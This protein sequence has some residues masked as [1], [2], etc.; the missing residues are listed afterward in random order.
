MESGIQEKHFDDADSLWRHLS[1]P[2]RDSDSDGEVIYRGHADADWE[3]VPTVLRPQ[4]IELLQDLIGRPMN[5]E[6][7]AWTELYMLQQFIRGCDEAGVAVPNDSVRF[8][9]INLTDRNFRKYYE[10]PNTWPS[11][12]LIEAIA[13]ARLHGLPTR[14]LDWTTDPYVAV[15]FAV[16]EALRTQSSWTTDHKIAVFELNKGE[17]TNTHCGQVRVL[18]VRGSISQNIVAQK[19]LFTV[20]PIPGGK[21][22]L[23]VTKSLEQYLPPPI[24]PIRKLTVP[25]KECVKLCH[26][27]R[28]LS[29][30]AAR[31]YPSADGASMFA[32]EDMFFTLAHQYLS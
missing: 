7:Q 3:L 28:Q 4:S 30:N 20:H 1:A 8:R 32:T 21:G 18:R 10:H 31:L 24:S 13:M 16:S 12:D 2:T 29:Y 9:D 5:C 22:E 15:Y 27:C 14:L 11:D 23:A 19:G 6:D 17:R 25:V 26:L